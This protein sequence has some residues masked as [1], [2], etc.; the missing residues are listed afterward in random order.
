MR[1]IEKLAILLGLVMFISF[2]LFIAD[3]INNYAGVIG[4][5]WAGVGI[6]CLLLIR[7]MLENE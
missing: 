6:V 2:G 5:L 7:T 4:G 1:L 3:I